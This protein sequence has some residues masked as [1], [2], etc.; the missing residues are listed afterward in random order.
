M[1]ALIKEQKI[2][3][4]NGLNL[5]SQQREN[6]ESPY[7]RTLINANI[8]SINKALSL[9]HEQLNNLSNPNHLPYLI[10]NLI[11]LDFLLAIPDIDIKNQL[12]PIL[13]RSEILEA[14]NITRIQLN[15]IYDLANEADS[16]NMARNLESRLISMLQ[17]EGKIDFKEIKNLTN[18]ERETLENPD[19]YSLIIEDKIAL[20]DIKKKGSYYKGNISPETRGLIPDAITA[21]NLT[22]TQRKNINVPVVTAL[23]IENKLTV[24]QAQTLESTQIDTLNSLLVKQLIDMALLEVSTAIKLSDNQIQ[25]I[26]KAFNHPYLHTLILSGQLDLN[27][28]ITNEIKVTPIIGELLACNKLSVNEAIKLRNETINN[29]DS[30]A[31]VNLWLN[32]DITLEEIKEIGG[33]ISTLQQKSLDFEP[34]IN[35]ISNKKILLHDALFK[36]SNAE[37]LIQTKRKIGFVNSEITRFIEALV[38]SNDVDT[39]SSKKYKKL[40]TE[41]Q[42]K[43]SESNNNPDYQKTSGTP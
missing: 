4:E 43:E 8:L 33:Q 18:V 41:Q 16:I 27:K 19:I 35:S 38:I 37:S 32:G 11:D 34:I 29:L 30:T 20:F 15:S 36:V 22:E 10:H 1:R 39:N 17:L 40:L 12:Y 6:I 14:Y 21:L 24:E 42:E 23:I 7:I 9:D 28:I 13:S 26:S 2:S 3:L 25:K 31:L 5:E